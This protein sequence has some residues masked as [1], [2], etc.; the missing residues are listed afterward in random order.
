MVDAISQKEA[1]MSL[2]RRRFLEGTGVG[3][4]VGA[5]W[6]AEAGKPAAKIP[7]RLLG[8]TGVRVSILAMGGG[9]RFL[10]FKEEDK[11]LEALARAFELGI[12][13]ID[14]AYGYG[15]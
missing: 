8:R 2:S 1:R 9:S 12:T 5:A 13:Y 3:V 11:A 7:T 15:N 14:T 4:A 6:R 10:M